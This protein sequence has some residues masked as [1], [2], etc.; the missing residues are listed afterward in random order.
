M[1]GILAGLSGE[2]STLELLQKNAR[3]EGITVGSH[4]QQRDMIEAVEA[5]RLEPVI[6]SHFPLEDLADAFR[7]QESQRHFGKICVD[8]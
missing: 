7:H 2:V 8:L 3:I 1:I 4:A 5:H 6:D